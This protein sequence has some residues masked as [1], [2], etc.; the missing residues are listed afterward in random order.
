MR[1]SCHFRDTWKSDVMSTP[2]FWRH[3]PPRPAGVKLLRIL[4]HAGFAS[5][6]SPKAHMT[7]LM[8]GLRRS[9]GA[10]FIF[11][12]CRSSSPTTRHEF[13][14][15]CW[16]MIGFRTS[17]VGNVSGLLD[18]RSCQPSPGTPKQPVERDVFAMTARIATR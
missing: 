9:L 13:T 15:M 16:S 14:A 12:T 10:V 7:H 6:S 4:R 2:G 18:S 11:R 8:C 17:S 1:L 3:L 5:T